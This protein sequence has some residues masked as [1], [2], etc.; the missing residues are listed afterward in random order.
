MIGLRALLSKRGVVALVAACGLQCAWNAHAQPVNPPPGKSLIFMYRA[1]R[2]AVAARVPVVANADRLGDIGNGEY[3][4]TSVNPGRTFLRAGDRVL[5]TLALQTAP[6]QTYYVLLEAVGSNPVRV[7]MHQVPASTARDSLARSRPASAAPRAPLA[8]APAAAAAAARPSAPAAA[9]AAVPAAPPRPAPA[10]AAPPPPQRQAAQP[11]AQAKP[12]AAPEP[13]EEEEEDQRIW[14]LAVI[15]KTGAFS[16]SETTQAIAGQPSSFKKGSKPVVG[17][18]AEFR[19]R[20]GLALGGEAFY[21]K[22]EV[23]LNGT[24]LQGDQEVVAGMLNAKYYFTANNWLHPFIG[25]GGGASNAKFSGGARGTMAGSVYQAMVGADLRFS[26]RFGLYLEYKFLK[27]T[28]SDNSGQT[29]DVGGSG[30]LA[31]LSFVF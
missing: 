30:I 29:I 21:Y 11:S 26:R 14:K 12:A 27:S 3:V 8:A 13:E 24:T 31:G 2:Q 18:E 6:N 9:P 5:S 25:V 7:D 28:T 10:P 15:A 19:H 4:S 16:L 1:D 17:L 22:N 20:N 23:S